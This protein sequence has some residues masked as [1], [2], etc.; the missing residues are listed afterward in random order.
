MVNTLIPQSFSRSSSLQT[1]FLSDKTSSTPFDS[2]KDLVQK[3]ELTS[4]VTKNSEFLYEVDSG[5]GIADIVLFQKRRGW[6]NSYSLVDI[7]PKWVY[8]LISLPY[9]KTFSLDDFI[10][11]AGVS[12]PAARKVVNEFVL[13]GF[14][15]EIGGNWIKVKQP[16]PPINQIYAIE[17][18]LK[19]WKRALY[20]ATRYQDF[21]NQSWVLLDSHHS[22]PALDNLEEF[23][24][25][26]IGLLTI[27]IEGHI[28]ILHEAKSCLPRSN[29]RYW[30]SSA[31]LLCGTSKQ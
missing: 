6:Q 22:R 28:S 23:K 14:C 9:R 7:G 18:K 11:L 5:F 30:Y 8:T 3:F 17:A 20:Q 24:K 29:Y 26:N 31:K 16:R 27:S 12:R 13:A 25:R 19:N 21:A 2:E 1:H 15:K 4:L 10:D